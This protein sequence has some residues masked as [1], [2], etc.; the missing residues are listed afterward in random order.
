MYKIEGSYNVSLRAQGYDSIIGFQTI[1]LYTLDSCLKNIFIPNA[2]SPND[3]GENDV[4]YVR[5]I[6]VTELDFRLFNRWGEQVFYTDKLSKG[7]D[8]FYKK[9]KQTQQVFVFKCTVTFYDGEVRKF[10]GN[11]TLLE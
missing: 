8:A 5:G 10:E 7:W 11:I 6:N 9:Q 1:E 2:F 3:D 4:L